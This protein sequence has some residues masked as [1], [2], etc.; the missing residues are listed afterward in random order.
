MG[1]L[2]LFEVASMP[3][4]QVLLISGLGALM[5]TEYFN[6]LPADARRSLNKVWTYWMFI[7]IEFVE[8]NCSEEKTFSAD[9]VWQVM[10][11]GL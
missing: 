5:A 10:K 8:K 7:Y 11:H 9:W 1:F 3:I 4:I 2:T 6:L